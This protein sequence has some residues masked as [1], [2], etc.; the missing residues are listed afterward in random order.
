MP[1]IKEIMDQAVS[2]EEMTATFPSDTAAF[3]VRHRCYRWR[4]QQRKQGIFRYDDLVIRKVEGEPVLV[5][6][7]LVD[8]VV[9]SPPKDPEDFR[10]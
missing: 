4:L 10:R 5:F 8:D 2:D 1:T 9:L 6:S 7:T 3:S